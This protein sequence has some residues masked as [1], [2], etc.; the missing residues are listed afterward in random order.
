MSI[1]AVISIIWTH[2][3]KTIHTVFNS[4]NEM[5]ASDD[6]VW[7]FTDFR[8][9]I[10]VNINIGFFLL[11]NAE[12]MTIFAFLAFFADTCFEIAAQ[13]FFVID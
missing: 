8:S 13:C 10:R 6:S 3:I 2:P 9:W 7:H 11:L 4:V 1:V 12:I 5:L